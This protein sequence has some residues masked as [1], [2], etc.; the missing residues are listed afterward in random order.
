MLRTALIWLTVIA[1]IVGGITL[2]MAAADAP[3][4]GVAGIGGADTLRAVPPA[5]RMQAA[6]SHCHPAGAGSPDL[7]AVTL[8]VPSWHALRVLADAPAARPV[9]IPASDPEAPGTGAALR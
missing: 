1:L 4:D 2:P 8:D 9:P 5:A 3:S 7:N 6:H